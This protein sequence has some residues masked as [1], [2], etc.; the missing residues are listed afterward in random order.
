MLTLDKLAQCHTA[1]IIDVV[2][3]DASMKQRLLDLGFYEGTLIEKVLISPK[4][5]PHAYK[6]RGTTIAL[7]QSDAQYIHVQE[8]KK[9]D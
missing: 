6:V 9:N 4:N 7:R 8:V 2:H 3:P 5:D 1:E